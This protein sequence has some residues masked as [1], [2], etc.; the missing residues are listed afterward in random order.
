MDDLTRRLVLAGIARAADIMDSVDPDDRSSTEVDLVD[1]VKDWLLASPNDPAVRSLLLQAVTSWESVIQPAARP[2]AD[3][4]DD[5][6]M[7]A[8]LTKASEAFWNTFAL[9]YPELT[10]GDVDPMSSIEW[11]GFVEK[12][13]RSWL[14]ANEIA[15]VLDR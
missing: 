15:E 4:Q 14:R 3:L 1:V 2:L 5:D 8:S 11:D 10:T 6:R 13:A 12:H 9:Q 7:N